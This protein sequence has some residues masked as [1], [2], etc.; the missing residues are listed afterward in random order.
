MNFSYELTNIVTSYLKNLKEMIS[1]NAKIILSLRS[2]N[3][4][5]CENYNIKLQDI[6]NILL[7]LNINDFCN[8]LKNKS[9]NC[10]EILYLFTK[11]VKIGNMRKKIQL[12]IKINKLSDKNVI[13]VVSFHKVE[14]KLKTKFRKEYT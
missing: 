10:N 8:I 11:V 2:K 9:I 4:I 6:K 12:Y 3:I 13:I 14:H 1:K 5:F 7:D